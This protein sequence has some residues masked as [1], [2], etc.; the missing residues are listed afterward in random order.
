[1]KVQVEEWG[2]WLDA[3]NDQEKQLLETFGKQ[4]IRVS[5]EKNGWWGI[6]LA[7]PELAGLRQI[8]VNR[9]QHALL[10][11]SLPAA[12]KVIAE[13][14]TR[15]AETLKLK[16]DFMGLLSQLLLAPEP[17]TPVMPKRP[18]PTTAPSESKSKL[19]TASF[20]PRATSL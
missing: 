19:A 3:E 6:S 18:S 17:V 7:S 14:E 11:F 8:L 13:M 4:G 12:A 2:I 10:S 16:S 20:I 9:E 5:G 1:M 15:D